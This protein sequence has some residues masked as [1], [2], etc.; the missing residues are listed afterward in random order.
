MLRL[1]K[2][3][4]RRLYNLKLSKI[5][6][7]HAEWLVKVF[8]DIQDRGSLIKKVFQKAGI[9]DALSMDYLMN[10]NPF[11]EDDIRH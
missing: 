1:L 2:K 7:L 10:K 3:L 5:K 4:F 6:P 11:D 9:T 8:T